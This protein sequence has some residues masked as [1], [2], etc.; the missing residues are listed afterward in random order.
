MKEP[1]YALTMSAKPFN[2]RGLAMVCPISQGAAARTHGTVVMLM[3]AGTNAQ[4]AVHCHQLESL[5]WRI[6]KARLKEKV[7]QN[8]VDDVGARIEAILFG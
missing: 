2:E 4:R 8:I 7:P 6:R 3:G 5:D 1:P